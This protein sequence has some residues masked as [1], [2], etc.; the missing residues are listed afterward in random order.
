VKVRIVQIDQEAI[1]P[2]TREMKK[3]SLT[4]T[5]VDYLFGAFLEGT[6]KLL[7]W[8]GVKVYST[9]YILKTIYVRPEYRLRGVYRKLL[10][11]HLSAFND[12]PIEA[13]CTPSSFP[14]MI[15]YG[16]KVVKEYKNGCK[17]V[18]K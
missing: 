1:K 18:I 17:K 6:D 8:A 16:F 7:G 4:L 15:K 3:A 5:N 10:E 12:K 13:V 9:K 14:C 11:Y 2:Y